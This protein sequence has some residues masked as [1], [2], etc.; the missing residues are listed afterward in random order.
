VLGDWA[1]VRNF[2]Q[3]SMTPPGGAAIAREGYTQTIVR[4][5]SDGKWRLSRDANLLA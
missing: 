4:K 1:Y 3:I 5:D 2:L